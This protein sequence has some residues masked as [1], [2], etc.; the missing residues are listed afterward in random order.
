MG[1][2]RLMA[3]LLPLM[4]VATA[5]LF[6][7]AVPFALLAMVVMLIR[8]ACIQHVQER[9]EKVMIHQMFARMTRKVPSNV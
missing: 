6:V 2:P 4:C 8:P 1:N 3:V 7:L 5:I 9:A